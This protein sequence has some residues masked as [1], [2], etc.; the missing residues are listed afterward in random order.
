MG[1]R[2]VL[3]ESPEPHLFIQKTAK[4]ESDMLAPVADVRESRV[5]RPFPE[6]IGRYE[7]LLPIASGGMATVYLGRSRGIG[8][9]ERDVAV[10]LT[11]AHLVT[12][13]EVAAELIEEAKLAVRVRHTNVVPVL[14]V[15]EDRFGLFL[16]MEYV[17]GD[18]LSGLQRRAAKSGN[19]L[20]SAVG[21]RILVDAL[22][23]LHAAHELKDERGQ[24]VGLVHRDFSPQNILVGLDG[25]SRLTDFGVAKAASRMSHTQ[26]GGIK[27][28][29]AYMSPEQ[30]RARPVDRRCDVWAAGVVAWELLAG[31]RLYDSNQDDVGILLQIA[32]QV[33]PRLRSVAS[34]VPRELD[35]AVASAL[36]LDVEQRCPSAAAFERALLDACKAAGVALAGYGEVATVVESLCG[37]RLAERRARAKEVFELR[38]KVDTLAEPS[39]DTPFSTEGLRVPPD[40]KPDGA[41]AV[42][43]TVPLAISVGAPSD[44]TANTTSVSTS[45]ALRLL[46]SSRAHNLR[47]LA[48]VGLGTVVAVA[49]LGWLGLRN[50]GALPSEPSAAPSTGLRPDGAATGSVSADAEAPVAT[51]AA[52]FPGAAAASA[53]AQPEASSASATPSAKGKVPVAKKSV[54][55]A[56]APSPPPAVR[57]SAPSGGDS[58]GNGRK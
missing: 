39:A 31:R 17:E 5:T 26:A 34:G 28:K 12:S 48:V 15:G 21:L 46:A 20:S 45:Q 49:G 44:A 42:F 3:A 51:V 18:T 32:G 7:I 50:S 58:F 22:A 30:A 2:R 27:G 25:V 55:A 52:S 43:A 47:A 57:K 10:K 16:V 53:T 37:A 19:A 54:L 38:S 8:G 1:E 56:P 24:R 11:H 23:G 14:D 4:L 35:A 9:F 40:S 36:T 41:P 6:R 29:I 33:P 13:A